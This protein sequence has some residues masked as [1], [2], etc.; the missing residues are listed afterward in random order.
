MSSPAARSQPFLGIQSGNKVNSTLH[1]YLLFQTHSLSASKPLH[2][3]PGRESPPPHLAF[4][5]TESPPHMP[6]P[7]KFSA[8]LDRVTV[9]SGLSPPSGQ[10]H[11]LLSFSHSVTSNSSWIV[12]HQAPLSVGFPR[13]EY[14]NRYFLIQGIF[15]T[16]RWN[17]CLLLSRQILLPLNHRGSS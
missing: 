14:W 1:S 17:R 9:H 11:L 5:L 10:M 8:P 4:L 2:F 6:S 15:P 13:Q 16:W 7:V 12:A 3:L